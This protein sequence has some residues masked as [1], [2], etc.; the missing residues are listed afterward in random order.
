MG[1]WI[2]RVQIIATSERSGVDISFVDRSTEDEKQHQERCYHP[3]RT[4]HMK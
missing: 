1:S 4:M 2:M 3:K